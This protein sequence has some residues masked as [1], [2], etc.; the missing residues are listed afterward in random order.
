LWLLADISR[1]GHGDPKPDEPRNFVERSQM[2]PRDSE[3]VERCQVSGLASRFHVEVR[4]DAPDEFRF[5]A[6][7]G[8]HSGEK[9]QVAR[10]HCF[11]VDAERFRRRGKRDAKFS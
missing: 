6:Y 4:A 1:G 9:K 5:A 11:R 7:S 10:L 2:L 8:K 3:G